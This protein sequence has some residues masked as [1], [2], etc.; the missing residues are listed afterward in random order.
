MGGGVGGGGGGPEKKGSSLVSSPG[1]VSKRSGGEELIQIS[2]GE[3]DNDA[4]APEL[5]PFRRGKF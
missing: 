3:R 2:A 4:L 5:S 1:E